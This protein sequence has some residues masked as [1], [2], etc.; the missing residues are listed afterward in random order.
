MAGSL[1][2]EAVTYFKQLRKDGK[3]SQHWWKRRSHK[4]S[5]QKVV[6]YLPTSR[7]ESRVSICGK[8][9]TQMFRSE[10]G[11]P[12]TNLIRMES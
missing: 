11:T 9:V 6:L 12:F 10:A 8:K 5:N 2:A 4:C 3:L 7:M 1:P